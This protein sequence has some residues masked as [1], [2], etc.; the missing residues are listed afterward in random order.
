V[1]LIS[2]TNDETV[3]LS[4]L[5]CDSLWVKYV[6]DFLDL[7]RTAAATSDVPASD[8][9]KANLLLIKLCERFKSHV[10]ACVKQAAKQNHWILKFA[11]KN[12]PV[13]AAIMVKIE[14][15]CLSAT[16]CLLGC[17]LNQFNPCLSF[18]RREGVYLYFDFN[19]GVFVRSG[20]VVRQGF[21]ARHDKH[22]AASKEEKFS[23][24]FYFMYPSTEE[25]KKDK[26]DKL[27][28]FEHLT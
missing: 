22:F 6:I 23:N 5:L 2:L 25:K 1:H 16:S 9:E 7:E 13:L 3:L 18:P 8:K 28:N 24:H 4:T 17:N 14:L 11:L 27:G 15:K 20:K 19:R 10:E 21:Q 26:R 12:L